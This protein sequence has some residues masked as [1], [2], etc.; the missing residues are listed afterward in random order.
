M[1]D[2]SWDKIFNILFLI[3]F[4]LIIYIW[5]IRSQK[6]NKDYEQFKLIDSTNPTERYKK[7]IQEIRE[8]SKIIRTDDLIKKTDNVRT[9][10][11]LATWYPNTWIERIDSNGNPVY[12]SRKTKETFIESK[13]RFHYKNGTMD[14]IAD[15]TEFLE[16]DGKTIKEIYD[17]SIFNYKENQPKKTLIEKTGE[18]VESAGSNLLLVTP[19][20][21]KYEHENSM[22]GG[23][24]EGS[25]MASDPATL[26]SVA[27][28]QSNLKQF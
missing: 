10:Y 4:G 24:I 26:G 8:P 16:T 7:Y 25:L 5:I 21:W 9:D 17:Q 12:N 27:W 23:F 3:C 18:F 14:G 28:V 22:N 2:F 19:D 1:I 6:L 11:N 20:V 13:A 15:P